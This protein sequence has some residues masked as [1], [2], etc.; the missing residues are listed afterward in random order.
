M[1]NGRIWVESEPGRGSTFHFTAAV[2]KQS[3][4][5]RTNN[6]GGFQGLSVLVVDDNATNQSILREMLLSWQMNPTV[7]GTA[8]ATVN[9]I[10]EAIARQAQFSV[11]LLDATMPIIDGFA[12]AESLQRGGVSMRT[13][14][15]MLSSAAQ[16]EDADRCRA[17]GIGASVTKPARQSDIMDAI[18]SVLGDT[19]TD[20]VPIPELQSK[21]TG[22]ALRV[23]VAEDNP[24]NQ[25]LAMRLLQKAGHTVVVASTGR[26]ALRACDEQP[27]DLIL[28]DVQMPEMGGLEATRVLRE[29]EKTSSRRVA[30]IA[31]TAHA[32][33]GDRER[34][35]AAGMD[36]Y[37]SKP[38][39]PRKLFGAIDEAMLANK[40]RMTARIR[41]KSASATAPSERRIDVRFLLRRVEGDRGLMKELVSVFLEDT[42]RLVKELTEAVEKRD[43]PKIERT[44]HTLK[45]AVA[46]FGA[47]RARELAL[48]LETRGRERDLELAD[49]VLAE[50][51]KELAL[52]EAELSALIMEEA[53]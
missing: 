38:I 24:V 53:A 48:E 27:F 29:K 42:P 47:K 39:D 52:V 14:V 8:E 19:D 5:A 13:V 12:L 21:S 40:A 34:C 43:H 23:L 20:L 50:L 10:D 33:K 17:L 30:I 9:A 4:P 37:V 18:L 11:I 28:M 1:M 41:N 49:C 36:H 3:V 35:L 25:E 31:M 44:G 32:V 46:N 7:V 2:E 15:M 6:S 22:P 16:I 26:K 45:G 51:Q